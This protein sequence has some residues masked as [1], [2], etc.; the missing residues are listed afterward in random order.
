VKKLFGFVL[1]SA[2]AAAVAVAVWRQREVSQDARQPG[3]TAA[4]PVN[5]E[6]LE[7]AERLSRTLE[8]CKVTVKTNSVTR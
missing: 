3:T 4:K 1:L 8:N 5:R 2:V 6:I 7:N